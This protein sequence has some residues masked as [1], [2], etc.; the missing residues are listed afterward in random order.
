MAEEFKFIS[1]FINE[2]HA[3]VARHRAENSY[4]EIE[5]ILH[6]GRMTAYD[7]LLNA[8]D[9]IRKKGQ[10]IPLIQEVLISKE[11]SLSEEARFQWM[12]WI[13]ATL[14]LGRPHEWVHT[15]QE[16]LFSSFMA[17][18]KEFQRGNVPFEEFETFFNETK[19]LF[20]S[21]LEKPETFPFKETEQWKQWETN[22]YDLLWHFVE[23]G[24]PNID[25]TVGS[26][27][28]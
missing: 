22:Y 18:L 17:P 16:K 24:H 15:Y 2:Y 13:V 19:G 27:G 6:E 26:G 8:I 11:P 4:G 14:Y 3:A 7:N 23:N 28:C 1:Q 25:P 21:Y 10:L 12:C 5:R 9:T 20:L